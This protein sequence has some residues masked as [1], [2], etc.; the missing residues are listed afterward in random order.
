MI[1]L[2]SMKC[3]SIMIRTRS[4]YRQ[5]QP[6]TV[7]RKAIDKVAARATFFYLICDILTSEDKKNGYVSVH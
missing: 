4:G 6:K 5:K 7:V 2:K 1:C 3:Y